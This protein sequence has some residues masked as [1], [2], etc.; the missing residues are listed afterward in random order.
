MQQ[1]EASLEKLLDVFFVVGYLKARQPQII[2]ALPPNH[3]GATDE[4]HS[5]KC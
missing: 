4:N 2:S 1:A 3:F 5:P